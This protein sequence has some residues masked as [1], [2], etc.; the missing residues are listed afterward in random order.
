MNI[1]TPR[2]IG[3]F[4]Q[5][6]EMHRIHHQRGKHYKNFSDLPIWDMLFGT[7]DNPKTYKGKCGF[8]LERESKL[9]EMLFHRNVN[10]PYPPKEQS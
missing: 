9:Q 2:W 1:R 3:F 6:P 7:F 8:R 5:R 4:F 10:D